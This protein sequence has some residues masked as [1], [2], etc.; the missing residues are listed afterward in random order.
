[1]KK[2]STA[3][4]TSTKGGEQMVSKSSMEKM[5]YKAVKE[6]IADKKPQAKQQQPPLRSKPID[7]N[8][9]QA[10]KPLRKQPIKLDEVSGFPVQSQVQLDRSTLYQMV[11][12]YAKERRTK[13]A[14]KGQLTKRQLRPKR[15]MPLNRHTT[16]LH[17]AIQ[18]VIKDT[19]PKGGIEYNLRS[20]GKGRQ[21]TWFADVTLS[22]ELMEA[23]DMDDVYQTITSKSAATQEGAKNKAANRMLQVLNAAVLPYPKSSLHN[24]VMKLLKRPPWK[25]ELVYEIEERPFQEGD[26]ALEQPQGEEEDEEEED[27][28][29]EDVA[30]KPQQV[31]DGAIGTDGEAA[32]VEPAE[33]EQERRVFTATVKLTDD[34][35]R[36]EA[37][38]EGLREIDSLSFKGEERLSHEEA[39]RSAARKALLALA[40]PLITPP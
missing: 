27:E 2:P 25:D 15:R 5:I 26:E 21:T 38:H 40:D 24:E 34:L 16:D 9:A 22:D 30:E 8:E 39:E 17:N 18:Q 10:Q 32:A 4:K 23:L 14:K 29:V 7:T 33:Q 3:K 31:A 35:R 1:V 6:A 36:V 12:S 13:M 11:S 28:E 20:E 19:P 37:A